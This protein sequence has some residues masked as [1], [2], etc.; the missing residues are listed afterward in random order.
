MPKSKNRANHKQKLKARRIRI[1]ETTNIKKKQVKEWIQMM[2][3]QIKN[4]QIPAGD[5]TANVIDVATAES[6]IEPE[7]KVEEIVQETP[8]GGSGELK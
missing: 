6:V 5:P 8:V 3:E 2:Q 1:N 7:A 4:Q